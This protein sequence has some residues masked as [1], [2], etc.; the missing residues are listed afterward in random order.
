[1]V[2]C[3]HSESFVQTLKTLK[4]ICLPGSLPPWNVI[5]S[6][7]FQIPEEDESP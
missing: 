6:G 1:M 4:R 7:T 5:D 3:E 2:H